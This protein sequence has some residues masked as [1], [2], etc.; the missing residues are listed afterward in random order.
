MSRHLT[1]GEV[2]GEHSKLTVHISRDREVR[3][4]EA[5]QSDRVTFVQ[6]FRGEKNR[7]SRSG[8]HV[9]SDA[10]VKGGGATLSGSTTSLFFPLSFS[11]EVDRRGSAPAMTCPLS[12]Q[13]L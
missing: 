9:P 7:N 4:Q 13:S 1:D 2:V 10:E 5:T 12:S 11:G 8:G 3:H 6:K